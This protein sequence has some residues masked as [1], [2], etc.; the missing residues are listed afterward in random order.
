MYL[1]ED[2][3]VHTTFSDGRHSPQ[4]VLRAAR[5]MGLR[6]LGFA[7]HVRADTTWLPAYVRHLQWLRLDTQ[8]D[9]VIGV[10]TKVL[11][12]QGTLDLPDDLSGIERI[13]VADHRLPLGDEL[14]GPRQVKDA[15]KEGR[16]DEAGVID[17]MFTAYEGCLTRYRSIHLAHPLSF[18]GRVGI[19]ES[20]IPRERLRSMAR[21]AAESDASIEVSERWRCPTVETVEIFREAGVRVRCSSDAHAAEAVGRYDYVQWLSGHFH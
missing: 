8:L 10:E 19:E 13:L 11:D 4:D 9:L 18:L 20:A 12:P 3:H 5:S 1:D 17:A 7:D 6:C 15:I 2:H 16:V 14:L 21:L